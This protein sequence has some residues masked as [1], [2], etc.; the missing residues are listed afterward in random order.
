[1]YAEEHIVHILHIL[2]HAYFEYFAFFHSTLHHF[3]L[4]ITGLLY[5][6]DSNQDPPSPAIC[7]GQLNA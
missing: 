7:V 5:S 1:M 2:D 4:E 3:F 6:N